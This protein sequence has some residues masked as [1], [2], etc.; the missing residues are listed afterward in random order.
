AWTPVC[1]KQMKALDRSHDAFAHLNT[2]AVGLSV[3]SV[4]YP[5]APRPG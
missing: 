3:D 5:R 1:A 4:P 2:F